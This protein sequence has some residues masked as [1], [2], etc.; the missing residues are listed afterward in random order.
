MTKIDL[1][2]RSFLWS[3]FLNRLLEKFYLEN[4]LYS[5]NFL[6][7]RSFLFDLW[8]IFF[9]E[10]FKPGVFLLVEKITSFF[11]KWQR[12]FLFSWRMRYS[13]RERH[14]L[15]V[16]FQDMEPIFN[17][18]CRRR[19]KEYILKRYFV[20]ESIDSWWAIRVWDLFN[21]SF[22]RRFKGIF[23]YSRSIFFYRLG[24]K[25]EAIEAKNSEVTKRTQGPLQL[26]Q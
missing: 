5:D 26:N 21:S 14:W 25:R 17:S 18:L 3:A 9:G 24:V 20:L 22:R 11:F 6:H 19:F 2:Q 15:W 1:Q 10:F 16:S 8:R 7:D 23:L 13:K 4:F 12:F